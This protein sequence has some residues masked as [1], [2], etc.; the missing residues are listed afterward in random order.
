MRGMRASPAGVRVLNLY[1]FFST[2]VSACDPGDFTVATR[3]PS[4]A[5]F[6]V[7][8]MRNGVFEIDQPLVD[9]HHRR[10]PRELRGHHTVAAE[11]GG[12]GDG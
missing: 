2:C 3:V 10:L 1:M 12:A 9:T 6:G 7:C 8:S 4:L 11:G 5:T